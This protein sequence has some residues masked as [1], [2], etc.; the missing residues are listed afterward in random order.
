MPGPAGRGRGAHW[1]QRHLDAIERVRKLQAEGLTLRDIRARIG[2]G[3]GGER[4]GDGVLP[5]GS[6]GG[7]AA[8]AGA[9]GGRG[10]VLRTRAGWLV[11]VAPDVQVWVDASASPWRLHRIDA[12]LARLRRELSRAQ[13]PP[14]PWSAGAPAEGRE[15]SAGGGG[16]DN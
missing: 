9:G 3:D 6:A 7:E 11:D 8:Q 16:E 4:A 2:A 10:E 13:G 14:D 15:P 5:G 1:D 12:A